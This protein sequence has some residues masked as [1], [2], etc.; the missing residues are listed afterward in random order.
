MTRLI[1]SV[2]ALLAASVALAGC[3]GGGTNAAGTTVG[4]TVG[5]AGGV[6]G[7]RTTKSTTSFRMRVQGLETQLQAAVQKLRSGDLTGAA[8]AG[9]GVL[10]HCQSIVQGKLAT[11]A[12]TTQQQQAV[13]HLRLACQDLANATSKGTSGDMTAAKSLAKQALAEV[14]T[15]LK[16]LR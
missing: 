7:V 16:Q 1:I 13:S 3:G 15:A 9:G 6:A 14:Q 4:T 10:M 5:A 11:R 12:N 8:S 2:G